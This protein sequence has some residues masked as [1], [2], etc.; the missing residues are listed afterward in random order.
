MSVWRGLD[1]I[2]EWRRNRIPGLKQEEREPEHTLSRQEQEA[3]LGLDGRWEKGRGGT[4]GKWWTFL[5]SGFTQAWD[6]V[7]SV[8][9]Q[10]LGHS[11]SPPLQPLPEDMAG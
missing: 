8:R 2:W 1:R 7:K 3:S 9:T 4:K 5:V 10:V 6:D 11:P